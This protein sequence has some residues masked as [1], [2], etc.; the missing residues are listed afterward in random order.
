MNNLLDQYAYG[1][2]YFYR[3]NLID[4]IA[5]GYDHVP[6]PWDNF[7]D[8]AAHMSNARYYMSQA[9]GQIGHALLDAEAEDWKGVADAL[10]D[11][12]TGIIGAGRYLNEAYLEVFRAVLDLDAH[13]R[14]LNN[15][16]NIRLLLPHLAT[17]LRRFSD[18]YGE[19]SDALYI[20][21]NANSSGP[22]EPPCDP[23]EDPECFV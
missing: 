1:P 2:P 18:A 7:A 22:P 4:K 11:D 19:I 6:A 3:W 23:E 10:R 12:Y 9:N 14:D 5:Y 16:D 15:P 13:G 8:V 21:H 17:H 20:Y